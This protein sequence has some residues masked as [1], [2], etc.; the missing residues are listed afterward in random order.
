[1]VEDG[2]AEIPNKPGWGVELN[3]EAVRHYPPG[4]SKRTTNFRADGS[5][6]FT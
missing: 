6:A 2:Y 1:M 3:E 4:P 5:V